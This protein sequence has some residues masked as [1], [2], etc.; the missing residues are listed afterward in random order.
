MS[1]KLATSTLIVL[2]NSSPPVNRDIT[3]GCVIE[4]KRLKFFITFK[5][6]SIAPEKLDHN[7]ETS[8]DQTDAQQSTINEP[9]EETKWNL[10]VEADNK[11][12]A[13]DEIDGTEASEA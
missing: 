1:K 10:P 2:Y 13:D 5:I 7:Q 4:T 12:E 8:N 3:K 6:I 11:D 9:G